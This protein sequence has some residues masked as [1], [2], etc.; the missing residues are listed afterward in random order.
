MVESFSGRV[1]AGRGKQGQLHGLAHREEEPE[2]QI[3]F[4]R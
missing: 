4:P 1:R 2:G 3:L